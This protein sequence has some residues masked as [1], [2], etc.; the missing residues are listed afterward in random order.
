MDPDRRS[1][2]PSGAGADS[3]GYSVVVPTVGRPS[4]RRLL[5]SLA[6]ARGPAPDEI[7]VVDDRARAAGP[8][9]L[10]DGPVPVRVITSGGRG[11]AAARNCGWRSA[12]SG[13]IAFLDDDVEVDPAWPADLES[14]LQLL[15]D[16]A[17]ASQ[18]RVT[19]PLP[20]GRRP[21]DWE[22]NVA[23]LERACWA[24]ADMVYRR[25]ALEEVGGF[26]ER[27]PRAYR[28]DSDLGLRV[29]GAGW[30]ILQG[31][32]RVTHPVRPAGPMVSVRLQAGNAD[33]VLM[34]ALHGPDWRIRAF[35]G[36][37]RNGRHWAT[38]ASLLT[39]GAAAAAGHRRLA[40][41]AGAA[42][43]GLSA[44]LLWRRVAPGPRTGREVAVMAA[45]S[46]L[47]PPAA[48]AHTLRGQLARAR[49]ARTGRLPELGDS[50]PAVPYPTVR[51]RLRFGPVPRPVAAHPEW[52][53]KAI[54]FDRDGT[55]I[56]DRHYLSQPEGVLPLPGARW[57]V[58]RARDAGLALGVVTNQSG[59]ARGL[60]SGAQVEAVN[61]RVDRLI[62]PFGYWAVCFHGPD[63]G[64]RC[65]KPG[66]GLVEEATRA[67]GFEP[68]DCAVIGDIGADVAAA[69]S[70]GAR[71]VLVPTRRTRSAEI[72]EAYQV[73]PDLL[74]AVNLVL[75]GRC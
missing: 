29:T 63:D 56:A 62:G 50:Q 36:A 33:D 46:A 53:P 10:P 12:R 9:D 11:P 28:E 17:A 61:E 14:D 52:E 34:R 35:A 68:A 64:C 2:A 57:A 23:G 43:A 20:G 49:V 3:R 44:E 40:G 66:P 54:L 39:A 59:V 45:T 38:T 1:P 74:T 70:A 47:L 30:L 48:V 16:Q 71:A 6:A 7:V 51:A 67:L 15:P 25:S 5:E 73:A 27:F 21:T 31:D 26:D 37:G 24:T 58:R 8:L 72:R 4:L 19:V 41:A 60:M 18:G 32:R 22:R 75:G 13:W 55:L 65:R 42:W 69:R